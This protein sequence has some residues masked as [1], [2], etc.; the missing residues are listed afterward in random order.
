MSNLKVYA[1]GVY[2]VALHIFA[3]NGIFAWLDYMGW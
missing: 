3:L 1:L 2:I